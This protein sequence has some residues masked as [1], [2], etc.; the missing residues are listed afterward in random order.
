MARRQ[1]KGPV[2]PPPLPERELTD[3]QR[4][5]LAYMAKRHGR[6][7]FVASI[8]LFT[9]ADMVRMMNRKDD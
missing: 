9:P 6:P 1:G 5:F 3:L 2:D 7:C 8:H 4:R